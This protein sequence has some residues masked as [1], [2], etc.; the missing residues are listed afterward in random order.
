MTFNLSEKAEQMLDILYGP[1]FFFF[2]TNMLCTPTFQ[3]LLSLLR[4]CFFHKKYW[5]SK[6]S[7][8]GHAR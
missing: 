1:N 6:G 3:F 7:V 5:K 8:L 4:V 2:F